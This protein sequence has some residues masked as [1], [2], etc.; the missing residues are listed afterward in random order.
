M[1][2]DTAKYIIEK[3]F[4]ALQKNEESLG[5]L[6]NSGR[7]F[8]RRLWEVLSSLKEPSLVVI[9]KRLQN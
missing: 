3:S 8:F 5:I 7:A 1:E 2:L 4:K 9:Y 6:G